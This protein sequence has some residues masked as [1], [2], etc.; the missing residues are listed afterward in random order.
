MIATKSCYRYIRVCLV[1]LLGFASKVGAQTT[2]SRPDTSPNYTEY[3][4]FDECL[5]AIDREVTRFKDRPRVLEDT[6][7]YDWRIVFD[8]SP[9]QLHGLLSECFQKF[10]QDSIPESV[11]NSWLSHLSL[12]GRIDD[13]K[14]MAVHILDAGP[15]STRM[16]TLIGVVN[17][18]YT[19]IP[20]QYDWVNS[21][22]DSERQHPQASKPAYRYI[23]QALKIVSAMKVRDSLRV[24]DLS[25]DLIRYYKAIPQEERGMLEQAFFRT[26]ID[27]NKNELLDSIRSGDN[28]MIAFY[29]RI[30]KLAYDDHK[31][32]DPAYL[33]KSFPIIDAEYWFTKSNTGSDTIPLKKHR[34]FRQVPVAGKV[35]VVTF[36]D[37]CHRSYSSFKYG[38]SAGTSDCI[39]HFSVLRRVQSKFPEVEFTTHTKTYGYVGNSAALKLDD[40]AD[41]L[42]RHFMNHWGL[43]GNFAVSETEF[44][45]IQGLDQRRL[46]LPN[47]FRQSLSDSVGR[48][49]T[50][51]S[52][53]IDR[54]GRIVHVGSLS[55]PQSEE[56]FVEMLKATLGRKN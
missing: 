23:V 41:S 14:K 50:G 18:I 26:Q 13:M 11:R 55:H 43:A 40:E 53:I 1:V 15:D 19:T 34:T 5:S 47:T 54:N 10:N 45:R 39:A 3:R 4:N 12:F 31:P 24:A 21:L 17:A 49:A 46:D 29:E 33:G 6:L 38:R 42:A 51:G 56:M 35:N 36:M 28:A 8:T 2:F 27:I 48:G 44:I 25:D 20:Y 37:G 7:E 30:H 32:F 9:G 22:L 16:W 52:V